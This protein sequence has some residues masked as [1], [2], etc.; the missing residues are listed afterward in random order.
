[1]NELN[2]ILAEIEHRQAAGGEDFQVSLCE[3]TAYP[4]CD[5]IYG[6][7]PRSRRVLDVFHGMKKH[8]L[9]LPEKRALAKLEELKRSA[10]KLEK[11]NEDQ[12][13]G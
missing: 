1:M 8:L 12:R 5:G 11:D 6:G 7:D 10:A 13:R 3:I 9:T 4:D 2:A